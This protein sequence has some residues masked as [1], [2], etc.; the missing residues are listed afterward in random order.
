MRDDRARLRDILDAAEVVRRYL[1]GDRAA[2]DADP[3]VQSHVYRHVLIVGEAAWRLSNGPPP[4]TR[5]R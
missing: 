1:P 4:S 3:P 2:F 5:P